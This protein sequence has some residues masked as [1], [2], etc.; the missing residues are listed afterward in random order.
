MKEY[1]DTTI[2]K[3]QLY[4]AANYLYDR[5][6][7]HPQ[8]VETLSGYESDRG[9]LVEIADQAMKDDWRKIL[10]KAQQ[11]FAENNTYQEVYDK[12]K[13]A[14]FDPEIVHFIC[15]IWYQTKVRYVDYLI[16]SHTNIREGSQWV[17]ISA[18]GIMAMFY[19]NASW[20]SKIIWSLAF[21]ISAASW[22]Y[23]L[24]QKKMANALKK[25]LEEDFTKF[26]K[27]I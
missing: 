22:Y 10:N 24:H 18:M 7:S 20:L 21:L 13:P 17:I 2:R 6:M 9:L 3:I 27:L 14:D 15:K 5:Q 19:F 1:S 25:I 8:V 4:F 11:L 26:D 12:V 23:G 16:D